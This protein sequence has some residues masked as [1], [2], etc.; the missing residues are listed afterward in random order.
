MQRLDNCRGL[1]DGFV[2][3]QP[4]T[5][6]PKIPTPLFAQLDSRDAALWLHDVAGEADTEGVAELCRLP[7]NTV[8]SERS[9]E[10]FLQQL[11]IAEAIDDPLVRRRGLLQ[12]VDA[13]PARAILPPRHLAVLLLN[14]RGNQRRVGMAALTRRLTMLQSLRD[15]SVRNLVVAV[16]GAFAIPDD[17]GELWSDGFRTMITFVSDDPAAESIIQDWCEQFAAK[18]ANLIRLSPAQ[19]GDRLRKEYL[20]GRDG[21]AIYRIRDEQGNYRNVDGTS[22]DDPER[23]VLGSYELIG[24]E[25]LN[26]LLPSDL[27]A[28]EVEAFFADATSSWRPYA[29]GIVWERDASAWENVKTRLR[30]LDRRG[31]DENRILYITAETGAGATTFIRDIAWRSAAAGYPTLVA[32]R[33]PLQISAL[34]MVSFL[35]RLT[36]G[37]RDRADG[38]RLYATPC[39]IVFDEN[40]WDGKDDELLGFAREIERSG[41]RVCIVVAVGL[42]P[43][44]RM[45]G[46]RK[47]VEL[48][49]LSHSVPSDQAVLLGSH[50]NRF[51]APHSSARS[52]AEWRD[53]FS[54]TAVAN[55]QGIA[56]FWIVL[57]FWLQRQIDLGETIQSQVYR[58]FNDVVTDEPLRTAILHIAAFS[59]VKSPY[60]DALLPGTTDWPI[61]DKLKDA[62]RSLGALGLLRVSGELN[63]YWA[64]AHDLL[65]RYLLTA[66]FY[67]HK[68]RSA[69]GLGDTLNPEHLR[70]VVLKRISS[71]PALGRPDLRD[72]A[73]AFA[74]SIFKIDPEHGHG[75]FAPFWSEVLD[76]LDQMPRSV[77]TTSRTFLHHSAISR[78]RI[79]SDRQMFVMPD[80]ERVAL[81]R[82]SAADLRAAL[83]LDSPPGSESDL[84]LFNSLAHA[85]HDLAEAEAAAGIDNEIV[86]QTRLE[87]QEATKKAYSLNPDNTYVVETYARTLLSEG[88]AEP[89]LAAMR[90]LEVLTLAYSLMERPGAESRRSALGRLA[91]RAFDLL[92]TVGGSEHGDTETESGAIA[93]ALA[94]LGTGS[95][96]Q[97]GVPLADRSSDSRRIAADLLA[98]PLLAGNVQAI[99]LRYMLGIIDHP[100]DFELQ[101]ELL[102]SLQGTGPAFTPQMELELACL[103][104]QQ[105]RAHEGDRLFRQ[106]RRMWRHGDHFVEVPQRLHWLLDGMRVDR[107]QVR[108]TVSSNSSGRSFARVAE[109]E[110]TEVPFRAAEFGLERR[111]GAVLAAYVSFGHN[112]P[113]LR[114]LTAMRR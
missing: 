38:D 99:K 13:N 15:R 105:E 83:L 22:L 19:F 44:M 104:Y 18:P 113:L 85:L 66:L 74:V 65:G 69:A 43:G 45:L 108:A 68:A 10:P 49:N 24:A 58:Q 63:R 82:R 27:S 23:P 111:P 103:L 33:Q 41:R 72:I 35:T 1:S 5:K 93:L 84:N 54:S 40:H 107:R 28:A 88:K 53:F 64:M 30:A 32:R 55:D 8:L 34:E 16:A 39:V 71:L 91:E 62:R 114:P 50:L 25:A 101:A 87:A 47:C 96:R 109:F 9:D 80:M 81:L 51:L 31:S 36:D 14:G 7:W 21:A 75:T 6:E 77:R 3:K 48:A 86:A 52:E 110:N 73:D 102:Q 97:A 46:E 78:R 89:S 90:A 11:E 20:K 106:L 67:D 2:M 98:V 100:F 12:I 76:A 42:Y 94:A 57:S 4:I 60:P 70:F 29:A 56:A 59:T 26:P 37:Q 112:G 17:L 92:M 95:N 61:T 79:A